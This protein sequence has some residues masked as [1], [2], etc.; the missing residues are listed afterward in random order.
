[1]LS[2]ALY[3]SKGGVGKTATAVNLAYLCSL[4]GK[5]TLLWDLDMQASASFYYKIKPKVKG[6]AKKMMSGKSSIDKF[7]KSTEYDNLDV[8]PADFSERNL[9]IILGDMKKSKKRLKIILDELKS[10]Y[11]V[12]FIDAH[13]GLSLVTENIFTAADLILFP[14]IPTTL[15]LRTYEQVSNYFKENELDSKKIKPFFSMVD[16]RK[17]MHKSILEE[18]SAKKVF[19]K[20]YIPYSSV[21]EKMGLERAPLLSYSKRSAPALAYRDLWFELNSK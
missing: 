20:N 14:M 5:R 19:L 1:M 18:Y 2:V 12:V 16:K 21:V 8:L 6:G 15:S 13:P 11:D 10:D 7:I 17:A 3:N 4:E 9:D